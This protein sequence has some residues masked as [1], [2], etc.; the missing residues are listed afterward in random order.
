MMKIFFK[1]REL[2]ENLFKMIKKIMNL[3]CVA[4]IKK[5]SKKPTKSPFFCF[6]HSFKVVTISLAHFEKC[7]DIK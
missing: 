1:F 2:F 5:K 7:R 4:F 6:V 3:D